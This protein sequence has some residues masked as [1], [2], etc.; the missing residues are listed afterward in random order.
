MSEESFDD[1]SDYLVIF[2]ISPTATAHSVLSQFERFGKVDCFCFPGTVCHIGRAFIKYADAKGRECC[3]QMAGYNDFEKPAYET[4][5][6]SIL[7]HNLQVIVTPIQEK[8]AVLMRRKQKKSRN[9]NL[10]NIGNNIGESFYRGEDEIRRNIIDNRKR[11][12]FSDAEYS[13]SKKTVCFYNCPKNFSK[14]VLR[15]IFREGV[16]NFVIYNTGSV[17]QEK[18]QLAEQIDTKRIRITSV[19]YHED[20]ETTTITFSTHQQALAAI[21]QLN[22]DSNAFSSFRPI[23]HFDLRKKATAFPGAGIIPE[24]PLPPR[25]S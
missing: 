12:F 14:G 11:V 1:F 20:D 8:D 23:L 4:I 5:T 3:L 6:S 17:N 25:K 9:M 22:G 16:E 7:V 13:I 10:L 21:Y 24:H 19:K 2:D 15:E 18:K